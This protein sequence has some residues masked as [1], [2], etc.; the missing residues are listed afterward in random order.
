MGTPYL[1][2]LSYARFD[3]YLQMA[4]TDFHSKDDEVQGDVWEL[5]GDYDWSMSGESK[6]SYFAAGAFASCFRALAA[7]LEW[8]LTERSSETISAR[9]EFF[10]SVSFSGI[11]SKICT[12]IPTV[13]IR[14]R[15]SIN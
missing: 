4:T 12:A 1:K 13:F 5:S 3:A 10:S 2:S 8:E 14:S 11:A 7:L 9:V 15:T 6:R